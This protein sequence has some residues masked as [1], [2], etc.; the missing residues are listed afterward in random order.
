[1]QSKLVCDAKTTTL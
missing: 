1:M